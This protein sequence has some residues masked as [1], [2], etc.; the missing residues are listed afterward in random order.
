MFGEAVFSIP[1]SDYCSSHLSP[2]QTLSNILLLVDYNRYP[3]KWG[4]Y[5]PEI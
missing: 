2:L 1:V 3:M 4:K 5:Q